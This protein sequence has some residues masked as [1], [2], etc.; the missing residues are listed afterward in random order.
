MPYAVHEHVRVLRFQRPVAPGLDSRVHALEPVGQGLGGHPLSPQQLA[1]VVHA[2]GGDPG[3]V[4]VDQGFLDAL[5][6][7]P[8]AFDHSGLEDRALELGHLQFEPARPG[9]QLAFVMARPVR[10]P[11]VVSLV[12]DGIGYLVGLRVEHRVDD[13]LDLLAHHRVESGLEHD[14]IELY[15]FLGHGPCLFPI[16]VF[17]V[18]RLKIV[19]DAGHV[20]IQELKS[21]SA[22]DF[23]RYREIVFIDG[24]CGLTLPSIVSPNIN[25]VVF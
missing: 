17:N 11:C 16:A 10:L 8:V 20:H 6:A 14:V 2:A 19:H 4:H 3:Q 9:R 1:D 13:L 18:W 22:Q 21:Q 23:G 24:L 7:A 12:S 25:H 5:L 15:H